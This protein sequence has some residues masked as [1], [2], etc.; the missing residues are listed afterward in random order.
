MTTK[1]LKVTNEEK[2]NLIMRMLPPNNERISDLSNE[3]GVSTKRLYN[4]QKKA[5]EEGISPVVD[6]ESDNKWSSRDKFMIVVETMA[7]NEIE[8]GEFCRSKGLYRNQVEAWKI[9]CIGANNGNYIKPVK[10]LSAELKESKENEKKMA[11]ELRK[12]EAALAE[13]A[14]LLLLRKKARAIWEENEEE[15]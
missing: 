5:K 12:K 11:R 14:A 13:A 8:L 1:R 9:A 10:D 6:G 4:W 3:S 2:T 15:A 7:M